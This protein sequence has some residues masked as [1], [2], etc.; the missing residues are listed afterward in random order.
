MRLENETFGQWTFRTAA[1]HPGAFRNEMG[2]WLQYRANFFIWGAFHSHADKVWNSGRRHYSA[3]TIGEFLRHQ[4]VLAE[5]SDEF[6]INDHLW[7]D[8][9]RLYMLVHPER[10]GFF[11]TRGRRAA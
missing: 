3:R 5:H 4:T 9:A 11:E 8:L 6:K 7:P 2:E 1:A 10:S